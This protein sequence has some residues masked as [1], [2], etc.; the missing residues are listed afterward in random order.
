MAWIF[1]NIE[2]TAP[3][4]WG[5]DCENAMNLLEDRLIRTDSGE[6]TLPETLAELCADTIRAFPGLRHHQA[7]VWHAFLVQ[8]AA[9]ALE[10]AGSAELPGDAAGWRW[11]LRCLTPDWPEDEPWRLVTSADRP[12]F[13]QP[14]VPG[15]DLAPFKRRVDAPDAL[16]VLVTSK[17]HD[18]K[19]E[20]IA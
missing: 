15:G 10:A 9:L 11:A 12:A 2:K 1:G 6:L 3:P 8:L 16:D 17:N 13:F 14:P 20:R 19:A 7:P 5:P 4:A 18:V